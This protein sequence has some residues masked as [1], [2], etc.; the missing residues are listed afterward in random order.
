[1]KII[2]IDTKQNVLKAY[3]KL[4]SNDWTSI[5]QDI[6]TAIDSFSRLL[7]DIKIN[8]EKQYKSN[9]IYV[10]LNE[11]KN[12]TEKQDTKLF[13]IKYEKLVEEL[14]QLW[15]NNLWVNWIVAGKFRKELREES[16]GSIEQWC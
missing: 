10:M 4:D 15:Y 11:L 6:Q 13:L 1:M 9:K 16:P 12:S 5:N 7:T 8:D 3:S 14:N 2:G